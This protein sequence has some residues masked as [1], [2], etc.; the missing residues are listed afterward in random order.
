MKIEKEHFICIYSYLKKKYN[1]K[2]QLIKNTL[3][4]NHAN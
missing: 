1:N 2:K 3:H 4:V